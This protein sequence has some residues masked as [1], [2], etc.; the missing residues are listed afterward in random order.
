MTKLPLPGS[1]DGAIAQSE[2]LAAMTKARD[3]YVNL[4]D[5]QR[6]KVISDAQKPST[7]ID[8]ADGEK[9]CVYRQTTKR[10]DGPFRF[11]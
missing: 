4:V 1:E 11:V 2:R 7:P 10:W 3:E 6:L 8:L 9:V 5:E